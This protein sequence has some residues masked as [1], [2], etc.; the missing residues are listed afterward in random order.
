MAKRNNISAEQKRELEKARI[1]NKDKN[2]YRRLEALIM[3]AEGKS[4]DEI[5]QKTDYAKTYIYELVSKF[6]NQGIG[7][8]VD[9]HYQGNRRNMSLE[10]EKGFLEQY[11]KRAEQGKIIEVSEIKKAY[12][13]KVGHPIG[14]TQIYYVLHR[15][16]WRKVMPRSKH[17]KKASDEVI[18]ASKKLTKLS[19]K[20]WKILEA[21]KSD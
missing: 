13:E 15:H 8:I 6:C 2:V 3:R 9:N 4:C 20:R 1:R 5:A 18:E 11:K 7:A 12:E 10:E 19:G 14:A 21:E 16:G 17:P